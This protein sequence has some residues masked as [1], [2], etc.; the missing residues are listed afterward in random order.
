MVKPFEFACLF[1]RFKNAQTFLMDHLI[2]V[3]DFELDFVV[4]SRVN[5]P[6][7]LLLSFPKFTHHM[8]HLTLAIFDLLFQQQFL[9]HFGYWFDK[10]LSLS[11]SFSLLDFLLHYMFIYQSIQ[12]SVVLL[13]L[14]DQMTMLQLQFFLI[15]QLTRFIHNLRVSSIWLKLDILFH[16][17]LRSFLLFHRTATRQATCHG[18]HTTECSLSR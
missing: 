7:E 12:I 9:F 10:I 14:F 13:Q 8:F 15:H 4:G 18:H 2:Q 1:V 3:F 17:L 5:N 6:V 11:P 16:Q